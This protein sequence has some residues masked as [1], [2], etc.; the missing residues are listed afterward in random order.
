MPNQTEIIELEQKYWKAMQDN[1]I[2]CAISLTRFPYIL[3]GP[4]G[5]RLVVEDDFRELM[6]EKKDKMSESVELNNKLVE[7]L[8]ED[9]AV[10][11]YEA[12]LRGKTYLDASTWVRQNGN[13]LCAF[14]SESQKL[15]GFTSW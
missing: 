8:N 12:V 7:I 2:E 6:Q 13:W 3:L 14:H 11:T 1:D 10:I 15:Q 4:E 5:S 9:T